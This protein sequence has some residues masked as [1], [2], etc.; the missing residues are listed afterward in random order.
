MRFDFRKMLRSRT[1]RWSASAL[2]AVAVVLSSVRAA[3]LTEKP[4]QPGVAPLAMRY[5]DL[6]REIRQR[7]VDSLVIDPGSQITGWMHTSEASSPRS[8]RV[9]FAS[10]DADALVALATDANIGIAFAPRPPDRSGAVNLIVTLLITVGTGIVLYVAIN[11]QQGGAQVEGLDVSSGREGSART[12]FSDVAGNSAAIADLREV[13]EFLRD[14]KRFAGMGAKVPKGIL[15]EGPPGT[16]KTLMARALAGE[17]GTPFFAT[18]GPDFSGMFVGVGTMRV[19]QL[20]R[21]A[22]RAGGGVIFVDE[23]DSLGGRRGR[24]GGHPED[25]RTLNQFLVELDGFGPSEGIIV[26]AATNRAS[27]LDPALLRKGRFDRSVTVGLPSATER[28]EILKL[29]VER[30][31]MP[32][33]GDVEL[34]RLARLM[35]GASGADLESLLNEA[36]I[37]AVRDGAQRVS[38]QHMEEARDR[39]LLGRAREGFAVSDDER[40]LVALHEAGHAIAGL[41]F[42]PNDPLHKVTIQPRGGAMGVAFF[43]P[44][45]EAHLH[46]RAYLEGQVRKALGG[47]AAEALIYG[48][49]R[50]TS[51][52]GSDLQQATRIAKEM[53]YR[54]GMGSSTGLVTF[55]PDSGPVSGELHARMDT[56]VRTIISE[57]YDDVLALLRD[58]QPSLVAL[59]DALL[60]LET[61]TGE[62]AE[63]ILRQHEPHGQPGTERSVAA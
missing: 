47:R 20:F 33:E 14:P 61:L 11:R 55:D 56:D 46:S 48:D 42:C 59:A 58:R 43:Q 40:R 24:V 39:V 49:R 23:I 28:V 25:D 52:A 36:A 6:V 9:E 38:W 44:D 22:R 4:Q 53:V 30:R 16:G 26:V 27:D 13:V 60:E 32:L 2:A 51:G 63:A 37:L 34:T 50:I 3:G 19:K 10:R 21:R 12:T 57:G 62:E 35:P 1:V 8:F 5:S 45:H 18:S 7:R 31:G 54:L 41:V 15:L 29:H 17:A